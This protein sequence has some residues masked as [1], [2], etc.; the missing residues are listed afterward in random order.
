MNKI[1]R[2]VGAIMF[3]CFI[4][5]VISFAS[6][7]KTISGTVVSINGSQIILSTVS[8]ARYAAEVGSAQLTRKNG[9]VMKFSEILAGDK[10]EVKGTLWSD[11]SISAATLKDN[12]LYTHTGTFT[13]KIT[14]IN[15]PD[16]SFIMQSKTYGE[17]T[18]HANN[19]T[20]FTKNGGSSGYSD[21]A[22]GM[23]ASV[24][25]VWDRSRTNITAFSVEG[26]FRMISIYFIGNLSV[27]NGTSLT[28]I[29][30]GNVIY[31]VD[32]SKA[33]ILNKN[34]KPVSLGVY[35]LGDT[36]RVWG[37]HISGMVAV[38][39]SEIKDINVIK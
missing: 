30:N 11:N 17:Q 35:S 27:K 39:A 28:V 15:P 31:G 9:A 10:V 3:M 18:I 16:S 19:F 29:G 20:M 12:S 25:G 1:Y 23:T 38:T 34:G 33:L 5:P 37:K 26:N 24:K 14:S 22:L 6:S 4:T 36:I 8:A 21:L 2:L 32:I 7:V 13:G